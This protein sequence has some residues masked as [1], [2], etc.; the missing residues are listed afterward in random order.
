[1][2]LLTRHEQAVRRFAASTGV[3]P[4]DTGEALSFPD[5]ATRDEMGAKYRFD[6]KDQGEARAGMQ[7]FQ[8]SSD[9]KRFS[10]YRK[11]LY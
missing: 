7:K 3:K 8:R 10:P 5:K 11:R 4:R 2:A 6:S 1:M 9:Y